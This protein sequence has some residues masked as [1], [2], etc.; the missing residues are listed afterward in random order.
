MAFQFYGDCYYGEGTYKGHGPATSETG[1][2]E[3][4]GIKFFSLVNDTVVN[5][6][7]SIELK[8]NF[9]TAIA[10]TRKLVEQR[11][12]LLGTVKRQIR[13]FIVGYAREHAR[14]E[15]YLKSVQA[16][17]IYVPIYTEPIRPLGNGSIQGVNSISVDDVSKYY[18]L[19]NLTN[20]VAVIDERDDPITPEIH[21][22]ASASENYISIGGSGIY[23]NFLRQVTTFYPLMLS[24][25]T[26]KS[27]TDHADDKTVCELTFTE[28]F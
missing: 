28:Y 20:Y 24:M 13:A 2:G 1:S 11:K 5:W 8:Y 15:H 4:T 6:G 17:Q 9:V 18:N 19:R 16:S 12:S 21:P 7:E 26:S 14:I 22:L 25:L 3:E 23:R 27:F 10:S